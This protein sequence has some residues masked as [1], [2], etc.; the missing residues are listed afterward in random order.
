MPIKIMFNPG[1]IVVQAASTEPDSKLIGA[2]MSDVL[3]L[4]HAD[5]SAVRTGSPEQAMGWNFYVISVDVK[6]VRQLVQ[7]PENA[8]LDSK[9]D[10]LEQKF[11]GWLNN[12][13]RAGKVEDRV[14]FNLLSDLQ[15][16]RYG[17]F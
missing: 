10:S 6:V 8:I 2:L 16:S 13:A 7:L 9:G 5:E 1:L 14:H 4:V 11:V 3:Q 12:R 15:S 17:L